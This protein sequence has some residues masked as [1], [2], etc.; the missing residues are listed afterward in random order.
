METGATYSSPFDEHLV[1]CNMSQ[2]KQNQQHQQRQ[3][4]DELERK[5]HDLK[6]TTKR[7]LE[8]SSNE[9]DDLK[10]QNCFLRC[11]V[12][13]LESSLQL[14]DNVRS[15]MMRGG[16]GGN[17]NTTRD[18]RR[19]DDCEASALDPPC[20]GNRRSSLEVGFSPS[21]AVHFED[22]PEEAND[23]TGAPTAGLGR[24]MSRNQARGHPNNKSN[25]GLNQSLVGGMRR[26]GGRSAVSDGGRSA[27]SNLN[28]SLVGF[29]GGGRRATGRTMSN[30]RNS[31]E[32]TSSYQVSFRSGRSLAS[33]SVAGRDDPNFS[34]ELEEVLKNGGLLSDLDRHGRDGQPEE[35]SSRVSTG[36][37]RFAVNRKFNNKNSADHQLQADHAHPAASSEASVGSSKRLHTTRSLGS[38]GHFGRSGGG[39]TQ[40]ARMGAA[41]NDEETTKTAGSDPGRR[42]IYAAAAV[43]AP[44]VAIAGSLKRLHPSNRP[45]KMTEHEKDLRRMIQSMTTGFTVTI[46]TIQ[47]KL[48]G[49]QA[50]ISTLQKINVLRQENLKG[51]QTELEDLDQRDD[52]RQTIG[53]DVADL[54]SHSDEITHHIVSLKKEADI[55]RSITHK[56]LSLRSLPGVFNEARLSPNDGADARSAFTPPHFASIQNAFTSLSSSRTTTSSFKANRYV[57]HQI[58]PPIGDAS[59]KSMLAGCDAADVLST[60]STVVSR[61]SSSSSSKNMRG[62]DRERIAMR[63]RAY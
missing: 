31:V 7:V 38:A 35:E 43:A 44:A 36:R 12:A 60:S 50:A 59:V 29:I 15:A 17:D 51:L 4:I 37:R 61:G 16:G 49:K 48:Q 9:I 56:S 55:S 54:K 18:R 10:A 23:A 41:G 24:L 2:H 52:E 8:S 42:I 25:G 34:K 46:D 40:R 53:S 1:S 62:G 45:H 6:Q 39:G 19:G 30:L 5:L 20:A 21:R 26:A 3:R 11:D 32:S 28:Q 14:K 13:T 22:E 57:K 33:S 58:H 63:P 47:E 27:T